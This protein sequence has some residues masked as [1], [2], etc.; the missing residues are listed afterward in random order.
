A[1]KWSGPV[2]ASPICAGGLEKATQFR[3]ARW[4][5]GYPG[6]RGASV[7]CCSIGAAIL[8]RNLP[9]TALSASGFY[10]NINIINKL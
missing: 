3:P 2:D 9:A 8:L 7:S 6:W 10:T 5:T 4:L 1:Q